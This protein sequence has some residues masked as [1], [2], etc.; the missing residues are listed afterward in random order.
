MRTYKNVFTKDHKK[1]LNN[2][3]KFE[4][5][6]FYWADSA[7]KKGDKSFHF[8][9]HAIYDS[10]KDNSSLAKPLRLLLQEISSKI[11]HSY[12]HIY[13]CALNITFC[14]GYTKKCPPH[15]DHVFKHKQILIYLNNSDGDTIVLDKKGKELKRV[16]PEAYK[17]FV[18]DDS[19]HYYYFPKKGVRKVL[20][21]TTN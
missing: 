8:V 7:V 10:G 5:N 6:P 14:N 4:R 21:Y 15:K 12:D 16:K 1:F 20:V 13:R 11:N 2:I 17:I 9:H 19:K 3:F 18:F